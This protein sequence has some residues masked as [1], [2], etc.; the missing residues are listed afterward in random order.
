MQKRQYRTRRAFTGLKPSGGFMPYGTCSVVPYSRHKRVT[1]THGCRS[2]V[3]PP[4]SPLHHHYGV[5]RLRTQKPTHVKPTLAIL[6]PRGQPPLLIHPA[7][8]QAC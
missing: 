5:A 7:A 1:P 4:R 6:L 3:Q 2:S 8:R